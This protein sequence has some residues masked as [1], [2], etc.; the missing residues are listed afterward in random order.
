MFSLEKRKEKLD[1]SRSRSKSNRRKNNT[2]REPLPADNSSNSN[3]SNYNGSSESSTEKRT[4]RKKLTKETRE[5]YRKGN[6][7]ESK[8]KS[9][10]T[11][12]LGKDAKKS[13]ELLEE[14][15][16]EKLSGY[17]ELPKFLWTKVPLD[18]YIR[19]IDNESEEL[20]RGGFVKGISYVKGVNDFPCLK[21]SFGTSGKTKK[22]FTLDLRKVK[23]LY[24]KTHNNIFIEAAYMTVSLKNCQAE[25]EKL[26]QE[27][28]QMKKLI[29]I[30][31]NKVNKN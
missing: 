20:K 15:L 13:P 31:V 3:N 1:K 4:T 22:L 8:M 27:Q 23:S 9:N 29:A 26:K 17:I 25:I 30:I 10:I 21:L 5:T 18:S 19:Y 12:V 11:E 7:V 2:V 24:K 16:A 28:E 6:L 14:E